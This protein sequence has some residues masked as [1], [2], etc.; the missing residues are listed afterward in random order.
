MS[1]VLKIAGNDL[2]N[3]SDETLKILSNKEVISVNQD[4]MGKA[5]RRVYR[6]VDNTSEVWTRQL[7]DGSYAAVLF[8]KHDTQA[9]NITLQWRFIGLPSNHPATLRDL[10][11]F[12]DLGSFSDH[13]TATVQ[14]H[15]VVM[16]KATEVIALL[17][18]SLSSDP[19]LL[20]YEQTTKF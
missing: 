8:N 15:G 20:Y 11:S 14:P 13:Y 7:Y 18:S 12:S 6:S 17:K 10:W 3:M 5:G 4:P 2:R 9:Q 16:L 19:V 1:A